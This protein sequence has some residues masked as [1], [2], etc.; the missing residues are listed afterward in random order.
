MRLPNCILVLTS[1]MFA[2]CATP[3]APF[4]EF[5]RSV[6][7]THFDSATITIDPAEDLAKVLTP[8][9]HESV[10]TA[11]AT[12]IQEALE[13]KGFVLA[14]DG[15]APADLLITAYWQEVRNEWDHAALPIVEPNPSDPDRPA[16]PKLPA[17]RSGFQLVIEIADNRSGNVFW[18]AI[19][20]PAASLFEPNA[21]NAEATVLKLMANFPQRVEKDPNLPH[22]SLRPAE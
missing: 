11:T 22:I 6:D 4:A 17:V 15:E 7:F 19:T 8:S 12:S 2:G 1:L 20:A 18:R 3:S 10:L 13:E 9:A 16:M 14:S 21:S 5:V